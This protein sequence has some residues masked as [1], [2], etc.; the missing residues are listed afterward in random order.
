MLYTNKKQRPT[1]FASEVGHDSFISTPNSHSIMRHINV[2][3]SITLNAAQLDYLSDECQDINR[4]M[5]FKTILRMAAIEPFKVTKKN[6]SADLQ[7]GQFIASKVELAILWKCNRKTATRIIREFNQMGILRSEPSNRTTIHTLLCLSVWFTE[8]GMIKN[9]FF[10]SNPIV[11]PIEKPTR[12]AICVPPKAVS[13]TAETDKA[14]SA[15]SDVTLLPC[16][17]GKTETCHPLISHAGGTDEPKAASS[18]SLSSDDTQPIVCDSCLS[19]ET[20]ITDRPARFDDNPQL[21]EV[22]RNIKE[23]GGE[24]QQPPHNQS[25][26]LLQKDTTRGKGNEGK[27]EGEGN[28]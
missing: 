8:Q 5:C 17:E 3:Y 28:P 9:R 14:A 19:P 15:D 24:P 20:T 1:R 23:E 10:V 6:F 7:A 26:R 27:T 12:T 18:F 13:E 11:K 4:M 16:K 22:R 25:Q 21:D 2:R